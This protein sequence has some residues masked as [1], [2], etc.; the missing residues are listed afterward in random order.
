VDCHTHSVWAG[1]RVVEFARRL[2]GESYLDIMA[3]GGGILSTVN[4]TRAAT[5]D[6]LAVTCRARLTG[7][8]ARTCLLYHTARLQSEN[9]ACSR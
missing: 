4:A 3:Q 7:R 8:L 6:E 5:E 1:T 2:A 9:Q